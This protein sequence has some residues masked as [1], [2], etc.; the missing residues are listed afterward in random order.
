MLGTKF[1]I[2]QS[3]SRADSQRTLSYGTNR[4]SP[5]L[6]DAPE[7]LE[8]LYS[9]FCF[10]Y[11]APNDVAPPFCN[12][13]FPSSI[14]GWLANLGSDG[15]SPYRRFSPIFRLFE[16]CG[17][18]Q[19][20]ERMLKRKNPGAAPSGEPPT[21]KRKTDPGS[22]SFLSANVCG[23]DA[24][25]WANLK[26]MAD[27]NEIDVIMIQEGAPKKLVD[28]IVGEDW[29][30]FVTKEAPYARQ[31][32]GT[33]VPSS[34][35]RGSFNV[36]LKKKDA[37][38]F[39]LTPRTY[40]P[41]KSRSVM[42]KLLPKPEKQ[43]PNKR[44]RKPKINLNETN[45]LGVRCPQKVELTVPGHQAVSLYNYH[46][47]QGS[48]SKLGYSGMDASTGHEVLNMIID[49]DNT[50]YKMVIGDQNAHP[51]SMRLEYPHFDIISAT[52]SPT[53]LVHS[54]M[55]KGLNPTPID[56][57]QNGIDF[58]HKGMAGCSDHPPMA[59]TVKLPNST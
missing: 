56:L 40:A 49:D 23:F 12:S 14:P 47:P 50:P 44:V 8:L 17:I 32:A 15:A 51:S 57:G 43:D 5:I 7:I 6:A 48:G 11:S 59:F 25:K 33:S 29:V 4:K 39:S 55:T 18:V 20:S 16:P 1:W 54:A 42:A 27:D 34:V 58:N 2:I 13:C 22:I 3:G 45:K 53:E 21:K 19:C 41:E 37:D 10:L 46:A 36:T 26:R 35:G 38:H 9:V 28:S 24:L 52:A 30:S 31:I